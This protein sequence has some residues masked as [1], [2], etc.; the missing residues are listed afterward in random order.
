MADS[1]GA[2]GGETVSQSTGSNQEMGS[3]EERP[4]NNDPEVSQQQAGVIAPQ[5]LPNQ[6][7]TV[8]KSNLQSCR[9]ENF[10]Y[11]PVSLPGSRVREAFAMCPRCK[12]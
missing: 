10:S 8:Q 1:I 12:C 7:V 4:S 5:E 11:E 3:A 2:M 6:P 9:M